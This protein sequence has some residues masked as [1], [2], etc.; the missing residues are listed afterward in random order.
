MKIPHYTIP[1][2]V[3]MVSD[4][5]QSA[6]FEAY[7]VGG[8]VRDVMKGTEPNDWDVTTNATPEQ[9]QEIFEHTYY[10][11]TFGTV[12][13]V[14]DDPDHEYVSSAAPGEIGYPLGEVE[15]TP[16]RLE[17]A[18]SDNRHPDEVR[19]SQNLEDDLKRRDFTINAMY[20]D[21][22]N[23]EV[24]DFCGGIDDLKNKNMYIKSN[25]YLFRYF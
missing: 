2:Y 19:F 9:I 10:E 1:E 12:G 25:S 15:V 13:V 21:I 7:L 23:H 17:G 11:N 24:L 4:T 3:G 18:Y 5:L 6:G 14:V 8:C 22:T 16:Y 20:Y